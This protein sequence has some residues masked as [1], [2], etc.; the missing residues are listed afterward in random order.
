[1]YLKQICYPDLDCI[2]QIILNMDS[3][4]VCLK[5]IIP[6]L[7]FSRWVFSLAKV[8]QIIYLFFNVVF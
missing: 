8:Q 7:Y 3:S 1:M 4:F 2:L 6:I 5:Y